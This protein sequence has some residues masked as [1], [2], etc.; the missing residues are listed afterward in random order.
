MQALKN[1]AANAPLKM[2]K[3]LLNSIKSNYQFNPLISQFTNLLMKDGKKQR[4]L[5]LIMSAMEVVQKNSNQDEFTTVEKAISNV[6]PIVGLKKRKL[7]NKIDLQPKPL[8][9]KQSK[10]LAIL[11]IV[12]AASKRKEGG[13]AE[14]LGLELIGASNNKSEAI[15]RKIKLHEEA[16]K[17][18]SVLNR[19]PRLNKPILN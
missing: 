1:A 7:K 2:Q 18:R 9:D 12:E 10:R 13:F 4:A 6:Q 16:I 15:N 11:W 5:N 19:I 3:P 8:L 14:K 17:Y